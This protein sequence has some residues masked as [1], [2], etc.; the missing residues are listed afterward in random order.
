MRNSTIGYTNMYNAIC[1]INYNFW[2]KNDGEESSRKT[3]EDKITNLVT[4]IQKKKS[5]PL[6]T[7]NFKA[8][9]DT[10]RYRLIV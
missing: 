10:F 3:K 6:F 8:K 2:P 7:I 4:K 9:N 5:R 1:I